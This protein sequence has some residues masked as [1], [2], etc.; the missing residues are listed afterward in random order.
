MTLYQIQE[1]CNVEFHVAMISVCSYTI[2]KLNDAFERKITRA[3]EVV[4]R[5]IFLY[6]TETEGNF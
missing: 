5:N 1:L 6:V 3:A 4:G 2:F